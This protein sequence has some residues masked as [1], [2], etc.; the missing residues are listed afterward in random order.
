[1]SYIT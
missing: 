1:M